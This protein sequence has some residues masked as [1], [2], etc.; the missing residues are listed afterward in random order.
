MIE[1]ITQEL[2]D[3]GMFA[4]K[5][6]L[7]NIRKMCEDLGNPQDKLKTIHIAGTNGKG[8][9]S[10]TVETVLL[11]AGYKVG[12]YTSP[13]ILKLNERIALNGKD[14]SDEDIIKYYYMVKESIQKH[15]LKPSYFE[16]MTAM[17]YKYFVDNG[18]E[19]LVLETGLG[20]RIDST[21]LS[22]SEIAVV[23]NISKDHCEFLGDTIEEIAKEKLGIVKPCST[24]V[25]GQK[26]PELINNAASF[27]PKKIICVEDIYSNSSYKLNFD[28][29]TTEVTINGNAYEFSLFGEYQYNNFLT[30]YAILKELGIS[31]DIIKNACKK[32]K[33]PCRF[34][35]LKREKII[36][37]D[38]AHNIDGLEKLKTTI[39]KAYKPEEITVITSILKD[40]DRKNMAKLLEEI[41][42]DIILTS[43]SENKRGGTGQDLVEFFDG[44][45]N[46][47]TV[48]E[49]IT[50]AYSKALCSNSKVVLICGSFY[51]L[52]KFKEVVLNEQK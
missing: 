19:Y 31:D 45:K 26:I 13:H 25:I 41:S 21:N 43:L 7:E 3:Y 40:K 34:E 2:Y 11:E 38:G 47:I 30:A 46:T 14:I 42:S 5:M 8:S 33:W 36:V 51:L 28:N 18:V 23:T 12:K 27:N 9:T 1:K 49:D 15:K 24:L 29:F 50:N 22:K 39:L 32:V 20:G 37:L 35:V 6:Y 52:S 44:V 17:M 10:T 48:E 4:E 16:V